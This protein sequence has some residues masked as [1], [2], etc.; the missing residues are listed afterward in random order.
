[1]DL[2]VDILALVGLTSVVCMTIAYP[3]AVAVPVGILTVAWLR[4][5]EWPDVVK[6]TVSEPASDVRKAA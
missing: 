2:F 3:M 6:G 1:M 4:P 5:S